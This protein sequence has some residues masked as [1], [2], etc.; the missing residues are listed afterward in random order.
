[1]LREIP[2]WQASELH[3][4]MQRFVSSWRT[5][6]QLKMRNWQPESPKW[7]LRR[8]WWQSER[9]RAISQVLTMG[10]MG[11]I[12]MMQRQ[13]SATWAKMQTAAGWLAQSATQYNRPCRGFGR[14]RW[15]LTNWHN[16]YGGTQPTTSVTATRSTAY[17]NW[18]F[19]PSVNHKLMMMQLHL[20]PQHLE[21]LWSVLIL[22]PEYR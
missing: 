20:Y 18:W 7:C 5:Q 17:L 2:L 22:S 8:W 11:N 9:V 1:M 16:R 4:Q 14:R 3:I 19:R 13:S 21:N 10:T 12:R 15:S 6:G